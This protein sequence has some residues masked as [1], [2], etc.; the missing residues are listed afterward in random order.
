MHTTYRI[1]LNEN[2]RCASSELQKNEHCDGCAKRYL[3]KYR[4]ICVFIL[5]NSNATAQKN[6]YRLKDHSC[7]RRR[8]MCCMRQIKW[9]YIS[10]KSNAHKPEYNKYKTQANERKI[11]NRFQCVKNVGTKILLISPFISRILPFMSQA[12]TSQEC[13]R[14]LQHG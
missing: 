12:N 10:R 6:T 5:R 11:R 1:W 9:C 7:W 14:M 8:T 2:K 3:I 4:E 13:V